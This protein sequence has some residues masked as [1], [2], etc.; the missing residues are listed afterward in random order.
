MEKLKANGGY[1]DFKKKKADHE[2]QRRARL[3]NGLLSL[4]KAEREKTLRLQRAYSRKKMEAYRQRKNRKENAVSET[5]QVSSRRQSTTILKESYN[6]TSALSKAVAK[7]KRA[8]PS[9]STKKKQVLAKLLHSF[10]ESDVKEIV[11]NEVTA[12]ATSSVEKKSS[13]AVSSE[14]V[15]LVEMFYEK[16]DISRMSSNM[17]D[18]RKF[19]DPMTGSKE[20][21][22]VRYLMHRLEDVYKLFVKYIQKG[23]VPLV[24]YETSAILGK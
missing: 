8:L 12:E 5:T 4:P 23:K 21:K 15:A 3:K 13:R 2:K 6:T 22:Q 18:C 1:E 14:D 24:K 9:T 16:D 10:D 19:I 20:M 11:T 7:V 17:R